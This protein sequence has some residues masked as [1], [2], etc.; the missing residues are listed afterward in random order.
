MSDLYRSAL[1]ARFAKAPQLPPLPGEEDEEDEADDYVGSLPGGMGPPAAYVDRSLPRMIVVHILCATGLRE[2]LEQVANA[3]QTRVSLRSL[4]Q[5]S[6]S[7]QCKLLYQTQ[8]WMS[9]Y[10][11]RR[12]NMRMGR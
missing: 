9:E 12:P 3:P 10:T 6:L 11:T 4:L 2:H 5:A 8:I 1:Q 7:K